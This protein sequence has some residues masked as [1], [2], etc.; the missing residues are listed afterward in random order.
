MSSV[1]KLQF[2]R[3]NLQRILIDRP[4]SKSVISNNNNN[5]KFLQDTLVLFSFLLIERLSEK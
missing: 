1:I 4:F 3:T 2:K 5:N